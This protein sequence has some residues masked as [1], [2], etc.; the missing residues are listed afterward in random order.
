VR[1]TAR[2]PRQQSSIEIQ[3][4]G[5]RQIF[6]IRVAHEQAPAFTIPRRWIMREL[7]AGSWF[8]SCYSALRR[9]TAPERLGAPGEC[10]S[11]AH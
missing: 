2:S 7:A 3:S 5:S 11:W 1:F 4:P 9:P 10:Q 8:Q 6:A